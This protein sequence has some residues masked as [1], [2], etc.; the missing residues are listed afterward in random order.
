MEHPEKIYNTVSKKYITKNSQQYN[1]LLKSGYTLNNNRLYAPVKTYKIVTRPTTIKKVI[2]INLPDDAFIQIALNFSL[3]DVIT[4]CN[5]NKH[6]KEIVCNNEHFWKEKYELDYGTYSHNKFML[7]KN[8][9][10]GSIYNVNGFVN[11]KKYDFAEKTKNLI[12]LKIN[13]KNNYYIVVDI[14]QDLFIFG[15]IGYKPTIFNTPTKIFAKVKKITCNESVIFIMDEYDYLWYIELS[16][17]KIVSTGLRIKQFSC[18]N[19]YVLVI[20]IND[21][22]W[23]INNHDYKQIP[24]Q[25]KI[26]KVVCDSRTN[27]LLDINDNIWHFGKYTPVSLLKDGIGDKIIF[28]S[29]A[30]DVPVFGEHFPNIKKIKLRLNNQVIID[31]MGN[32]YMYNYNFGS[33]EFVLSKGASLENMNVSHVYFTN[34]ATIIIDDNY[35]V[36]YEKD[37]LIDARFKARKIVTKGIEIFAIKID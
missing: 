33:S 32:L 3:V 16:S 36:W 37:T 22:L 6:I 29:F 15:E 24:T 12:P 30:F 5:T 35:N 11:N 34:T 19:H 13:I 31:K 20:D 14:N 25:N 10:C 26:K 9:Y 23:M 21:N 7:W 17:L 18:N 8:A 1:N 4:M 28:E 27:L 2:D